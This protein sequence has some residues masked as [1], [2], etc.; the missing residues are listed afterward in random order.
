MVNTHAPFGR[1]WIKE[2]IT[3]KES[4]FTIIHSSPIFCK[5]FTNCHVCFHNTECKNAF[6]HL[7]MPKPLWQYLAGKRFYILNTSVKMTTGIL[8]TDTE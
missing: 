3:V 8:T 6:L 2:S 7:Y 4:L 5:I 1:K